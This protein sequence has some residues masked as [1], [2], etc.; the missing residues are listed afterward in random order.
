MMRPPVEREIKLRFASADAARR[1]VEASGAT[2]LRGRRLQEDTLLDTSEHALR[3]G[4]CTLRIRLEGAEGFVTFKG[5]VQPA[6]MKVREEMETSV[7]DGRTMLELFERLGFT[8]SIRYQ[9]YREEFS[10]PGVVVA[11]DETPAGVFVELE[12]DEQGI[13]RMASAL[14]CSER[15]YIRASYLTLFQ[16]HHEASGLPSP[17]VPFQP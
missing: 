14:G 9:K 7:G 11:I 6:T 1:A 15:D 13:A 17:D 10:A 3:Q 4:G 2:L 5:P 8:P 16:A 12:G